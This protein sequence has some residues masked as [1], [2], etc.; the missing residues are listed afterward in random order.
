MC[1]SQD[2]LIFGIPYFNPVISVIPAKYMFITACFYSAFALFERWRH[3]ARE[4]CHRGS[5]VLFFKLSRTKREGALAN[6]GKSL[7][8]NKQ[9]CDYTKVH[10]LRFVNNQMTFHVF[11]F[12]FSFNFIILLQ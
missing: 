12:L 3:H 9:M 2:S 1:I 5:V 4:F 10:Y 7:R 11:F 6:T 8:N